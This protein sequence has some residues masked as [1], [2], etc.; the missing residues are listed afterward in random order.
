MGM[1]D[2]LK[3][4]E[5]LKKRLSQLESKV[6]EKNSG[7]NAFGR[8]YSKVG[9]SDS[10]FL[11]Q[12][13]GQ[14]KIQWGK[15][16][17]D[18]IKDGKI[19]VDAKFIYK[20]D[21]VGI[22]D[23]IYVIGEGDEMQVIL[24]VGGEQINL[25]GDIGTTYVSFQG[26]QITTS[27][28]KYTALTNIGF[29]YKDLSSIDQTSLQNGL[30]YIESEKKLYVVQ[31]GALTEFSIDIPNPYTK[32]LVIQKTDTSKGSILIVGNGIENSLAFDQFY[33]YTDGGETIFESNGEICFKVYDSEKIRIKNDSVVFS[34][35]VVA[36]M[37]QSDGATS[38]KGFRLYYV[39]GES[40]LEV[41]NLIVRNSKE[42]LDLSNFQP[43]W[44]YYKNNVITD[45]VEVESPDDS[46]QVG[47]QA[48]LAFE[49][50]FE[51]GQ[52]LYSYV[53][54][55]DEETGT[56]KQLLLPLKV[57]MINTEDSAN[58]VYVSL[59][60]DLMDPNDLQSIEK[61]ALLEAIKGQIVSLI[62]IDG[63]SVVLLRRK[64]NNLDLVEV[65]SQEEALENDKVTSR[66]G[67][68]NELGLQGRENEV[69]VPIEG[70]G[71][72]SNNG[73]FL[74][75][76]YT[77]DYDL[78]PTDNSTKF[79]S[80]EWVSK[81]IPKGSIMMYNG[82]A[83]EIPDGWGVCD[84]TNGTPNLIDKFI[85]A[86]SS[87]GTEGG[88]EEIQLTIEHLPTHTHQLQSASVTTSTNGSHSH[89]YTAPVQGMSDN[90]NDRNVMETSTSGTTGVAGAH[91][92]TVDLSSVTLSESGEGKPL[93]WEPK[94]YSLIF[95]MKL[96]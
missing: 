9:S 91:S 53:S 63:E 47:F 25:K 82:L 67:N 94:Y 28:Q 73:A 88:E 7:M 75:A 96:F 46:S 95:I 51:V 79:A 45:A 39:G 5:S 64:S 8:A 56:Y 34:D 76:Q 31:E 62:S 90:A 42:T 4:I 55:K 52:K 86:G 32:Q 19:N 27:D 24:Q 60:E 58:D 50:E 83:S 6:Q 72:Y 11:I 71:V 84:G 57:E 17:I 69:E 10:D 49:N 80:T 89:S 12:T 30:I 40:T 33:L 48:T 38:V 21:Q 3:E 61:E 85:K 35:N 23:G 20:E 15:K 65:E 2:Q 26:E 54:L 22:K 29:L 93:K 78:P 81:L 59:I 68:L 1:I 74:K 92:H 37:F 77:K 18:L 44:W 13:K 41:D 70:S 87:S 43:I 66:F 36:Q 16:F 14:V